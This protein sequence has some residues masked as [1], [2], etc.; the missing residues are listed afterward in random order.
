M[1]N[2]TKVRLEAAK[3]YVAAEKSDPFCEARV[4][5]HMRNGIAGFTLKGEEAFYSAI[6]VQEERRL[7]SGPDGKPGET[8][9]VLVYHNMQRP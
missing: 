2:S 9:P 8:Y 7:P 6:P 1:I 3:H 5:L 4:A